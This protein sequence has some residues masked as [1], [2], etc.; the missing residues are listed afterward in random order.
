M[1]VA[2]YSTNTYKSNKQTSLEG[3]LRV[4]W[5]TDTAGNTLTPEQFDYT[6]IIS[7]VVGLLGVCLVS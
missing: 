4:L 7:F 2:Y 3:D 5:Y 6:A 1:S